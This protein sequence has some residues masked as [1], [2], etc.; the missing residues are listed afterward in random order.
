[1]GALKD[2]FGGF[3]ARA[4]H[5]ESLAEEKEIDFG[6]RGSRGATLTDTGRVFGAENP[7]L[8]KFDER[9]AR[10][11]SCAQRS[12]RERMLYEPSIRALPKGAECKESRSL[13]ESRL[14]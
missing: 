11:L 7:P 8:R 3:E 2:G 5:T 4:T 13:D 6:K 14:L 12:M 1:M 10:S 9:M